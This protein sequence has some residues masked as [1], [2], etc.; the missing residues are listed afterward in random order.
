MKTRFSACSGALVAVCLAACGSRAPSARTAGPDPWEGRGRE[1]VRPLVSRD[2]PYSELFSESEHEDPI[3]TRVPAEAGRTMRAAGLSPL[4]ARALHALEPHA[5]V[6]LDMLLTRQDLG[7]R[8]ISLESQLDA[9][10]FEAECTGELI[11]AM[12]FEL[13][14]RSDLRELRLAL[15]SLV[16]GALSATAAGIWDLKAGGSNGPAVLGL[17]G[18]LASAG[19][20]GAAF[21]KRPQAMDY[22]HERNLLQA[23]V[24]GSD[25]DELFPRFVYRLLT[26]PAAGGGPSPRDKLLVRWRGMIERVVEPGQRA[27]AEAL[28]YGRGGSYSQDLVTLR[29]RL[30]DALESELNA[31]ARDLELLDRFLVHALERS[32]TSEAD[33]G[34]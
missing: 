16:M 21:V 24:R 3:L 8:L 31:Q 17:S 25:D 32:Y 11:E 33:A 15:S 5:H 14:D 29:E 22:K 20:G 30:Y 34:H 2:S 28:L 6:S 23:V 13:E 18:G 26:L 12:A 1:C 27:A 4:V 19:L 9:V 7:M 10:I